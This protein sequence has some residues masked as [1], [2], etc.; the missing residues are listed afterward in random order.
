MSDTK[1]GNQIYQ[2][3]NERTKNAIRNIFFKGLFQIVNVV[4]PFIMRTVILHFLGVKYLGLNGLFRSILSILNLAEFGVGSAMVFS[5]YKPIADGDSEA[6]CALMKLYRTCYRIIG[7]VILAIGL[8]LTPFLPVLI[9]DEIPADVNLYILYY[10]SLGS[11]V[12]SYWLF[13]YRNSLLTAHQRSD[14]GSKV[15][16]VIHMIEYAL[17]IVVLA[18]FRNYYLYLVLQIISQAF[19]N[20]VTAMKSVQYYPQYAPRGNLSSQKVKNIVLRVRDLFTSKFAVVISDSADTLVVSS[21]LG[22]E[23][24]A[25][26]QNYFFVVSSLKTLIDVIFGSCLA[27]VGNSLVT[28]SKEKNYYDLRK[29]TILFGW[30]MNICTA[31]LLCMY[32]PFMLIWMGK[33]N[34]LTFSYVICFAVYFYFIGMNRLINMFKDASGIWKIDKWRPLVGAI[35]NLS[36]NLATV[37][38]FGLYGVI[39]STVI[40]VVFTQIPWLFHNLFKY[41]FPKKYLWQYAR[42]YFSFTIIT[43]ASCLTSL[44]LCSIPKLSAWPAFFVNAAISFIVPNILFLTIYGRSELFKASIRQLKSIFRIS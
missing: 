12:L 3:K 28:E 21:F 30:L 4:V 23:V 37:N 34:L 25:V 41:V 8:A 7:I 19:I 39:L 42:L 32:Q 33:E 2:M 40:S 17:K 6:I 24:L 27:G 36:L 18:I 43:L 29:M 9:K 15:A 44:Y 13:A 26:Y 10:L 14:V 31:M 38:I 1:A 16:L 35:V 22:L 5:M 20:I 11:T